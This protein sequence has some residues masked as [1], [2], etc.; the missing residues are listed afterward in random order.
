MALCPSDTTATTERLANENNINLKS[1]TRHSIGSQLGN[2][3]TNLNVIAEFLGHSDIRT[4]R[5]YTHIGIATL[6][7]VMGEEEKGHTFEGV[8]SS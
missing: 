1:G 8:K 3:S 5:R 6:R 7:N 2:N 4:T